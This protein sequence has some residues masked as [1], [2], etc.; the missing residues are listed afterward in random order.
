MF[1]T[2]FFKFLKYFGKGHAKQIWM[3]GVYTFLTSLFDFISVAIIL[4]FLIMLIDPSGMTGNKFLKLLQQFFNLDTEQEVFSYAAGILIATIILKNVYGIFIMYWQNKLLKEWALDIKQMFMRMYLYSPFEMNVKTGDSERFFQIERIVDTVFNNF[5]FRVIVFTSNNLCIGLIF[6]WMIY[7]LPKYSAI[8]ALFFIVSASLQNKL[9]YRRAK[10]YADKKYKLEKGSYNTLMLSLRYLKEIKITSSENYF[11]G[12]YDKISKRMLPWIERI[13]LL[14][15]VPQ[16]L[17]EIVFVITVI[18]LFVGIYL[19]YGMDTPKILI[20]LGIVA[21]SLFRILPLMYKSQVCINYIDMYREYPPKI[22]A[23]YDAFKK[24]ENYISVPVKDRMKFEKEITVEDLSYSYDKKKYVLQNINFTIKKGEYLGI[25]GLS[26]A[27]KTTLIDCISGLL[28]GHGVI[29]IDDQVL[30]AENTKS[31]QNIIGY[32]SQNTHTINAS[33]I[34]NIAWGIPEEEI[35]NERVMKSL[36]AANLYAQIDELPQGISTVINQ[37][38]SGLSQG[39]KQRIG[40]ARA[41]YRNPEILIFDEATSSLDVKTENDIMEI[42]SRKK[43]KITMIAVSHRL[44][45]LKQCDRIL[46]IEHG[47]IV[48]IDTFA[49]LTEKYSHFAEFVKLSNLTIN[50]NDEKIE[51]KET[52]KKDDNFEIT[53]EINKT[54]EDKTK[55]YPEDNK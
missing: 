43:G 5:V 11:Y 22:F 40:I 10:Q 27:G 34:T 17:I 9:I 16:Y 18:L 48:D 39:Q 13:N 1:Y 32:V 29:K 23:L 37:D 25:V 4:P 46:Y 50:Q 41:F 54:F 20:S 53:E 19:E 8:A 36:Q 21:I 33:L 12:V 51:L 38:G 47:K 49:N 31:Y 15:I 24:Y 2:T 42:L 55:N 30:N 28:L 7:I 45:T 35:D 14:P 6:L 26:G 3:M 44:S 52:E